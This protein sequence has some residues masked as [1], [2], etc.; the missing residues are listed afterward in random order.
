MISYFSPR[1]P[2]ASKVHHLD[3]K[4]PIFSTLTAHR[5]CPRSPADSRHTQ[6]HSPHQWRGHSPVQSCWRAYPGGRRRES[7]SPPLQW[8]G[9]HGNP[10]HTLHSGLL[11]CYDH[12]PGVEQDEVEVPSNAFYKSSQAGGDFS[13]TG[14]FNHFL[15]NSRVQEDSVPTIHSP[16]KGS[17]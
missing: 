12:T 6:T 14:S 3:H 11:L 2:V 1:A 17:Q 16:V 4:A 7:S 5:I 8:L 9:L 15:C 13:R 10:T